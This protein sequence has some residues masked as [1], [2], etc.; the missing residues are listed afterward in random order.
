MGLSLHDVVGL[1]VLPPDDSNHISLL[2]QQNFRPIRRKD[3]INLNS[4]SIAVVFRY[5]GDQYDPPS[6]EKAITG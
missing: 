3:I 1:L 6:L 4:R 5:G 2:A